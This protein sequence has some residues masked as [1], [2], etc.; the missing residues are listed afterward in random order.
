MHHFEILEV[1]MHG[2]IG[3]FE[4]PSINGPRFICTISKWIY[5]LVNLVSDSSHDRFGKVRFGNE[6]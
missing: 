3:E 4:I 2:F 1:Y 6:L 5:T